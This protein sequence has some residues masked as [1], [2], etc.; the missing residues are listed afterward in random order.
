M[1][2]AVLISAITSGVV[3]G[4]VAYRKGYKDAMKKALNDTK[5]IAFL[6]R[7]DLDL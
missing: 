5:K 3:V 6:R 1:F 7:S 4:V 2:W